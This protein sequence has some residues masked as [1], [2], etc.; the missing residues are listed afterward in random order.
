MQPVQKIEP[1]V[2]SFKRRLLFLLIAAVLLLTAVI[3]LLPRLQKKP[4]LLGT[5]GLGFANP[6]EKERFE[7]LVAIG[8]KSKDRTTASDSLI[9]AFLTL[10]SE[11]NRN[12]TSDKREA[13]QSLARYLEKNYPDA[14]KQANIAVPCKEEACGAVFNYSA[15]F[16]AVKNQVLGN[17]TID[18]AIKESVLLNLEN[19]ALASGTN[20]PDSQFNSLASAF[21][22]LQSFWQKTKDEGVKKLAKQILPLMEKSSPELYQSGVSLK[23]YE[24]K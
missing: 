20:T 18:R 4:P 24:L 7:E 12:P 10:S 8:E 3:F 1:T 2:L 16:L 19:A 13:L 9:K 11:Y 22:N 5:Q 14:A 6:S 21:Y 15:E 23:L 17:N